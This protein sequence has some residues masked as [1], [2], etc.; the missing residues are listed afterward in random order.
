MHKE[1]RQKSGNLRVLR[2]FKGI[3]YSVSLY[4]SCYHPCYGKLTM[5]VIVHATV[6]VNDVDYS[7]SIYVN[8][9]VWHNLLILPHV[10]PQFWI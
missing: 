1:L 6:K 10:A 8:L 2:E 7:A 5:Y 9:M 4:G 3:D